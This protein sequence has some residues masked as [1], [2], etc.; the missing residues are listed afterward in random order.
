MKVTGILNKDSSKLKKKR[1]LKDVI[2]NFLR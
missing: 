1:T 2:Q